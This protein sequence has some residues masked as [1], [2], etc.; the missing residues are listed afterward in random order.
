MAESTLGL[1]LRR[2][3]AHLAASRESQYINGNG[4]GHGRKYSIGV[5][6]AICHAPIA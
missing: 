4:T 1:V 3:T 5:P 6:V 2:G